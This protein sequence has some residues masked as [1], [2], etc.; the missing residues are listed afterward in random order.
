MCWYYKDNVDNLYS[1]II[2]LLN[3]CVL[4]DA[5]EGKFTHMV[6]KILEK[7]YKLQESCSH[8]FLDSNSVLFKSETQSIISSR[9]ERITE[10]ERRTITSMSSVESFVSAQAEV[11]NINYFS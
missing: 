2:Y 4:Q 6:E 9:H 1:R 11:S 3:G 8:L 10:S 5:E 7:A